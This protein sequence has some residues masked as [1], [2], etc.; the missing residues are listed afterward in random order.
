MTAHSWQTGPECPGRLGGKAHSEALG[1]KHA[2]L[3]AHH[4]QVVVSASVQEAAA[5]ARCI[6]QAA[7]LQL[8]AQAAGEIQPIPDVPARE[9]NAIFCCSQ[10]LSGR[11]SPP[12]QAECFAP[13]RTVCVNEESVLES[14]RRYLSNTLH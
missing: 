12:T 5:L 6:E 14:K 9:G 1:D 7:G 11:R 2:I 8:R 3:L 10:P 4:G 13:I